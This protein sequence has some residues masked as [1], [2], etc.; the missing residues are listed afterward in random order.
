M[1]SCLHITPA[2]DPSLQSDCARCFAIGA[3]K[4]LC[5]VASYSELSFQMHETSYR[6]SES[7]I[8]AGGVIVFWVKGCVGR[9]IRDCRCI[10]LYCIVLYSG[11]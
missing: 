7:W 5:S 9:W 8:D 2:R 11:L 1:L 3:K 4:L 10:V 6:N